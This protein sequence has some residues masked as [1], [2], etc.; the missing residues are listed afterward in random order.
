M[1]MFLPRLL[2]LAAAMYPIDGWAEGPIRV[3]WSGPLSG[4]AA[5][6][7]IDSVEA[8]RLALDEFN[9]AGGAAGRTVELIVE[10]DQYD[11]AKAV[12]AYSKLVN[13]GVV[14]ILASTYG[15]VFATAERAVTDGVV[16]IDPLDCNEAIAA[17]PQNTFC[18]ATQSESI[19]EALAADI[20]ASRSGP[21]AV[22]YDEKNPFMDIVQGVLRK[23]FGSDP[24]SLFLP[25]DPP[26]TDMRSLL[27]KVKASGAD[28]LVL[29][30]HDP[31]GQAMRDARALG[32]RAQFFTVGTITSPGF[33]KLA[34]PAAH[35]ARVAYWEAPRGERLTQFLAAFE[36]HTGRPPILELAT[37][38]T[39]DAMRILLNA[40]KAAADTKAGPVDRQ[41]MRQALFVQN[42]EGLSGLISVDPDGAVRAIKETI[43]VFNDGRLT[44]A[45]AKELRE[46]EA[47]HAAGNE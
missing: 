29:L 47:V 17:L 43:Y 23:K 36:K 28:A 10:D 18:I 1:R 15:G 16:V 22:I 32:I 9:T 42:Y 46:F 34:G 38:P 5:V 11:T 44:N 30:G 14:A 24:A 3:G 8:A 39:Y 31:M 41:S 6:L 2:L 7:G 40:L 4:N 21:V 19:G 20:A 13:Q 25:A 27:L 33:Q 26:G 37:V 45:A 12:S 35:G